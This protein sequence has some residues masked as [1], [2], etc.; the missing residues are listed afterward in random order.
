MDVPTIPIDALGT[1]AARLDRCAERIAVQARTI[2][3]ATSEAWQGDAAD[4]HR[5]LVAGHTAD[6]EELARRLHEAATRVRQLDSTARQRVVDLGRVDR[7]IGLL[8]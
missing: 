1:T 4:R 5:E 3:C 2:R 8:P 6:L 7:R